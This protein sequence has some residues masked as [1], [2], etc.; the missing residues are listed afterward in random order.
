[1]DCPLPDNLLIAVKKKDTICLFQLNLV[2]RKS[3]LAQV[4]KV[5]YQ[6]SHAHEEGRS[7]RVHHCT[8]RP[9]SIV[10][11][12]PF[13]YRLQVGRP[14]FPQLGVSQHCQLVLTL[15]LLWNPERSWPSCRTIINITCMEC[16][17]QLE[18]VLEDQVAS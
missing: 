6:R 18:H 13:Q 15:E 1:M 2:N 12:Q 16:E 17:E 9:F 8:V 7:S 14:C 4:L 3:K 10:E 5:S 11:F